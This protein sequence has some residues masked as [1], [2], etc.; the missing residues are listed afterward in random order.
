MTRFKISE[1]A[2]L[3][4]LNRITLYKHVKKGIV[5]AGIDAQGNKYI[6]AAELHR[7]YGATMGNSKK[8]PEATAGNTDLGAI[9]NELKL[10]RESNSAVVAELAAIKQELRERPRLTHSPMKAITASHPIET[11]SNPKTAPRTPQE[12]IQ[13]LAEK[14]GRR[15]TAAEVGKAIKDFKKTTEGS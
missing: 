8:D 11:T 3:V 14:L 2:K 5:S 1:A 10:L 4:G 6:D 13:S 7:A 9:L 15:P 12:F